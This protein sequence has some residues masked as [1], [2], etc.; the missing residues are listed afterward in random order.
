MLKEHT[1]WLFSIQGRKARGWLHSGQ[2]LSVPV[3]VWITSFYLSSLLY[4]T[5]ENPFKTK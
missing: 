5:S 3:G 4:L 2:R 1:Q